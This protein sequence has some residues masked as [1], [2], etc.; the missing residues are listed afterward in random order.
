[1]CVCVCVCLSKVLVLIR[2]TSVGL[3]FDNSVNYGGKS[4]EAYVL[5]CACAHLPHGRCVIS[6]KVLFSD[7]QSMLVQQEH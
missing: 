3:C 5:A 2:L 1:M 6:K 4:L 7:P